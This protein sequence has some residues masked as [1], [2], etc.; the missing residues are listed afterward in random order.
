[1]ASCYQTEMSAIQIEGVFQNQKLECPVVV[2]FDQHLGSVH[3][4]NWLKYAF[5]TFLAQTS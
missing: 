3:S 5:F 1:M 4:K 2:Y